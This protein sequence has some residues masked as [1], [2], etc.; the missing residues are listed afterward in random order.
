MNGSRRLFIAMFLISVAFH[1][2]LGAA[3]SAHKLHSVQNLAV[4]AP[5]IFSVVKLAIPTAHEEP[6][7]LNSG[8]IQAPMSALT[9]NLQVKSLANRVDFPDENM[10]IS[11]L[12][13]ASSNVAPHAP[14]GPFQSEIDPKKAWINVAESVNYSLLQGISMDVTQGDYH[15]QEELDVRV[16]ARGDLNIE[17]P[18]LAAALG[19]EAVV[20]VLLLI[21]EK[22]QK[23]S[24]RI[25]RGDADFNSYV[26][27]ALESIEFRPAILKGAAVRSL[28]ILEFEFR[29]DPP[30]VGSF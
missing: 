6:P 2:L 5:P 10:Q 24:V 3:W 23:V 30:L 1:L 19:K 17:Y 29:R 28:M 13:Q 16:R 9:N 12:S 7:H 26:L 21:D 15:L 20:Y 11:T 4:I 25:V 22:G 14:L 18:L 8:S 27:H